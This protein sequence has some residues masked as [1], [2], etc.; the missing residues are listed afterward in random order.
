MVPCVCKDV[1]AVLEK[2][3]TR[4][5]NIKSH[6]GGKIIIIDAG[7]SESQN[8]LISGDHVLLHLSH[9]YG[10]APSAMWI[11]DTLDSEP[12]DTA[13]DPNI[14]GLTTVPRTPSMQM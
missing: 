10:G 14:N 12:I 6:C 9:A 8:A 11:R 2:T 1:E 13:D 5:M 3:G 4:R 7:I